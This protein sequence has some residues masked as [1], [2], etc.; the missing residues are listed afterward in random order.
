M[1]DFGVQRRRIHYAIPDRTTA[2]DA[3]TAAVPVVL[4]V[5]E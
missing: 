3:P 2:A 1:I 5:S 4:A